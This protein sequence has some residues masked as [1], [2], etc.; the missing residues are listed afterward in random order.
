MAGL[1]RKEY[2]DIIPLCDDR[3]IWRANECYGDRTQL[4]EAFAII[5]GDSF[6]DTLK[7]LAFRDLRSMA[8]TEKALLFCGKVHAE[9]RSENRCVCRNYDLLMLVAGTKII[10]VQ[11]LEDVGCSAYV[12]EVK[13]INDSYYFVDEGEVLYI[14]ANHNHV[15][16]HCMDCEIESGDSLHHLETILSDNFVRIQRGYLVNRKHVKC[17]RR[18]E[19]IM[20]NGDILPIPSKKYVSVRK[21]LE[22]NKLGG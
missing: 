10:Y 22:T 11:I 9:W 19:A 6:L 5:S 2:S 4:S 15:I 7:E 3:M 21:K 16:W 12:H 1:L 17:L 14:E 20:R 8:V 13:A 18:C